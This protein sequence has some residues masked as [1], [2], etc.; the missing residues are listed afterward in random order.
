M[1]LRHVILLEEAVEDLEIGREFYDDQDEGVGAYF[2]TSLLSDIASL[3][4]YSGV[5]PIHFGFHRLLS[6][7]FPFAVY[8]ELVEEGS[9][10]IAVL[11]MRQDPR[12]IRRSLV[13]RKN[14]QEGSHKGSAS[15]P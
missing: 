5:H 9:R 11:D 15:N 3:H 7:R 6:K 4:L 2:V 8:Y 1:N 12:G 10:V 14:Q 13:F